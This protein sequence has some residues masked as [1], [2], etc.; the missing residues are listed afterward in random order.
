[1]IVRMT[2]E[3]EKMLPEPVLKPEFIAKMRKRQKGKVVKVTDFK[4]RYGLR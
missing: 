3:Y 2:L 4:K 1:M